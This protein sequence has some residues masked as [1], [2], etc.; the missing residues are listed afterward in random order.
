MIVRITARGYVN[1]G[2]SELQLLR[3]TSR[4]RRR[5]RFEPNDTISHLIFDRPKLFQ[6]TVDTTVLSEEARAR[7][8]HFRHD[9]IVAHRFPPTRRKSGNRITTAHALHQSREES[10]LRAVD[11]P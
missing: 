4:P 5:T 2:R 1:N 7:F 3:L 8:V 11:R 6:Q 9:R 10:R